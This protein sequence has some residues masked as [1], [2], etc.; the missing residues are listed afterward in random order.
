MGF[1]HMVAHNRPSTA[2]A[3]VADN[4]APTRADQISQR[5]KRLQE[6]A[7]S[8]AREHVNALTKA[9][10]QVEQLS[11][12]IAGGGE[13]YPAGVRDIARR[14]AEDTA[15]RSQTIAAINSRV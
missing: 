15:A 2:L 9:L 4:T 8:L 5:V 1:K 6:E 10:I 11:V 14:L 3:V 12:E 7:R 13:A